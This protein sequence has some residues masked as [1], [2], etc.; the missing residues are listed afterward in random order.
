MKRILARIVLPLVAII[1]A[2]AWI[3]PTPVLALAPGQNWVDNDYPDALDNVM[4]NPDTTNMSATASHVNGD[5]M[6]DTVRRILG[7]VQGV[8]TV[9]QDPNYLQRMADQSAIAGVSR[10]IAA[11]YENKP[12]STYAFVQ[13]LG[14][15]LGFIHK[16][17]YAQGIGFSGLAPLLPIWKAFRNIAYLLLAIVMIVIG[18]MVMFR[19]KIDP[20][21]VVTV[22][23]ALPRIVVVLLLI[24][25]SYAIVGVLIDLMY[26][27]I[28]L[29][30]NILVP[31][32]AGKL[33]NSVTETT[34]KYL[35]GGSWTLLGAMFW[36]GMSSFDDLMRLVFGPLAATSTSSPPEILFKL[37][38]S[39]F[40]SPLLGIGGAL[41]MLILGVAILFG[42]IRVL[43]LLIGAYINV[44]ISLLFAPLQILA[45]AFPG[46]TAFSSWF[47]NLIANLAVFPITVVLILIGTILTR[48]NTVDLWVPPLLGGT[49]G[50]T[51]GSWVGII[52]LGMLFIIPTIAGS[53]KE[54]LKAK[55][56]PSGG[57]AVAGIFG[58]T[59][60]MVMQGYQLIASHQMMEAYRKSI[61]GANKGGGGGHGEG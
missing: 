31:A 18:F 43:V 54:A 2:V 23:N 7:P 45:D 25:F 16:S 39:V 34:S 29:A 57:A 20:K 12:A 51:A 1:F 8:T 14:Q 41:G 38:A 46:S 27:L 44:V 11:V 5:I 47:L 21:T 10:A 48:Q 33:G 50:N 42:Y 26:L 53:L 15:T 4:T 17:A 35:T 30:I 60:S 3:V 52:G 58:Q 37:A 19:K 59:A 49:G 32:A 6:A 13:D 24:T 61:P 9:S 28:V 22:Q 55:G 40:L 36:G 56:V